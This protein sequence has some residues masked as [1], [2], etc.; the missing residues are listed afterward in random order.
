MK[1]QVWLK[2]DADPENEQ[3]V[4]IMSVEMYDEHKA[5]VQLLEIRAPRRNG[6]ENLDDEQ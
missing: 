5:L 3:D 6:F 4:L 1:G 2:E